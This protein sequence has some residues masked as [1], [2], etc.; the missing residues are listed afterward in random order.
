MSLDLGKTATQIER[1]ADDMRSRRSDVEGRLNRARRQVES[2]DTSEY[3]AKRARSSDTLNWTP[4]RVDEDPS[5]RFEPPSIPDDFCV[6]AVDGSHIDV[7]R[8]LPARC[9]LVNIGSCTF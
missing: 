9:C 1:M 5:A 3:E 4:P 7:D 6:A 8:H 2:F